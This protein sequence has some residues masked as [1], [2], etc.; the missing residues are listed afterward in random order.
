MKA[1]RLV[2]LGVAIAAGGVAALLASRSGHEP[3]AP[4]PVA[5]D[6]VDILVA[7]NELGRGQLIT[8]GD[9]GWQ[10]WPIPAANPSFIKRPD[11]PDAVNQFVGAIVRQPLVAG[12]PIRDPAVVFAKAGGFMAAVLPAGMR[13]VA[14]E[15]SPESAAGGFVLPDDHVDIVLTRRDKEVEKETGVEKY[16]SETILRNVPVLAVDQAVE[17]KNGQKV[18][19]GKTATIEL[20]PEQAERLALSRQLGTLSLVLRSL[21]DSPA[22]TPESGEEH[23]DVTSSINTVRYGVSSLN[24]PR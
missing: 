10:S 15:I 11:R 16:V 18:A 9:V 13:A 8:A 7:K 24:A 14:L 2:V 17:E 5:V 21:A 22:T 1:A 20:T 19:V 23:R 6:T 12:D 4:K 3:E